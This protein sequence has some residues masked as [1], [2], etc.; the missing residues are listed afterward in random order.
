MF[1]SIMRWFKIHLEKFEVSYLSEVI[2]KK[3]L[4]YVLQ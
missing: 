4:Q 1:R 2:Y 3:N